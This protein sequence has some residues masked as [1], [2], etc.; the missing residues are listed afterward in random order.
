MPSLQLINSHLVIDINK[1]RVVFISGLSQLGLLVPWKHSKCYFLLPLVSKATS[2]IY[3]LVFKAMDLKPYNCWNKIPFTT[4]SFCNQ[5]NAV[6]PLDTSR[7]LKMTHSGMLLC[8]WHQCQGRVSARAPLPRYY[9]TSDMKAK[10]QPT[11]MWG[12]LNCRWERRRLKKQIWLK[13]LHVPC[14]CWGWN[15]AAPHRRESPRMESTTGAE[16]IT[17]LALML[18]HMAAISPSFQSR[19]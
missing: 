8:D 10:P 5:S 9:L 19:K 2:S 13:L 7:I 6:S 14:C 1:G 17:T 11:C 16:Q 3:Q 18:I 15:M 4:W 12:G